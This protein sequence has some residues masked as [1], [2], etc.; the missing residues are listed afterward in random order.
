MNEKIRNLIQGLHKK[1]TAF[2]L[3]VLSLFIVIFIGQTFF[4]DIFQKI[5]L[6]L[7][8][9]LLTILTMI[10]WASAGRAVMKSLFVIGAS[11][12]LIIYLAQSYCEVPYPTQSGNDALKALIGFALLYICFDFIKLLCKEIKEKIKTLKQMNENKHLWIFLIPFGLFIVLFVWNIAQVL[13]PIFQNL[14]VYK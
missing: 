4:H 8:L 14:C 11:L 10:T 5:S 9:I 7:P 2:F 6:W 12:T 13:M 3:T 1:E